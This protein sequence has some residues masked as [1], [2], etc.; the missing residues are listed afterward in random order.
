MTKCIPCVGATGAL[1]AVAAAAAI[2]FVSV[3]SSAAVADVVG[4]V[5]RVREWAFQTPPGGTREDLF[6]RYDV[7][8]GA[9]L[10]TVPNGALNVRFVDDSELSLGADTSMVIDSF[11]FDTGGGDK[12]ELNLPL[13]AMRFITGRIAHEAVNIRTPSA[14]IGIRGTNV[15]LVVPPSLVTYVSVYSGLVTV[16]ALTSGATRDVP[17]GQAVEVSA[18]GKTITPVSQRSVPEEMGGGN[19]GFPAGSRSGGDAGPADD[20]GTDSGGIGGSTGDSHGDNG[21]KSSGDSSGDSAGDSSG[22]TS[23][24]DGV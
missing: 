15:V 5:T 23:G 1:R 19:G 24:S 17:S 9:R 21:G 7:V 12:A 20:T 16:T 18:D 3:A 22:D 4:E 11:V 14:G 10:E 2:L 13:G 8:S 6:V